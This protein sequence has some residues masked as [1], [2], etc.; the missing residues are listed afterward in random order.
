MSSGTNKTIENICV[1]SIESGALDCFDQLRIIVEQPSTPFDTLVVIFSL[2][3]SVVLGVVSYILALWGFKIAREAAEIA[4][5]ANKLYEDEQVAI[6]H[7]NQLTVTPNLYMSSYMDTEIGS[8]TFKLFNNGLG[9]AVIDSFKVEFNQ[10][11]MNSDKQLIEKIREFFPDNYL[12]KLKVKLLHFDRNTYFEAD[13]EHVLIA[14]T[15]NLYPGWNYEKIY[16][17]LSD[18]KKLIQVRVEY[19]DL[20]GKRFES[21]R[22]R[23]E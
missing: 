16:S 10:E 20:Y 8:A 15:I 18:I 11:P 4:E 5:K 6:R 9:P 2:T 13:K 22:L 3:A 21:I 14:V 7:H 23:S 1:K 19:T 12:Y 17:E